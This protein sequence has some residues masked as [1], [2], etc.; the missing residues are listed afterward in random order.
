MV[1]A[2]IAFSPSRVFGYRPLCAS[3]LPR[4]DRITRPRKQHRLMLAVLGLRLIPF[5]SFDA[6]SYL[7]GLTSI[8]AR[9]VAFATTLG[10]LPASFAFAAL[11]AGMATLDN[12]L[13]LATA[14][15][16]TLVLP[17]GWQLW[18]RIWRRA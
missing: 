18:P 14:C 9:N 17:A 5:I 13:L 12:T 16:V 4:T 8:S 2:I 10:I 6:V 15:G 3:N 1:G 7:A 11:G